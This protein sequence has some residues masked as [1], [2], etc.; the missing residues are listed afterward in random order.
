MIYKTTGVLL[1]YRLEKSAFLMVNADYKFAEM[2]VW[3]SDDL[4]TAVLLAPDVEIAVDD[5]FRNLIE[6]NIDMHME[7]S[8]D[9]N[10]GKYN[11]KALVLKND[12]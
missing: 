1:E 12:K 9:E 5:S 11:L 10:N 2:N 6:S 8:I 7:F 4:T 3:G